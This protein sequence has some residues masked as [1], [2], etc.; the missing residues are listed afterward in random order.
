MSQIPENPSLARPTFA[1]TARGTSRVGTAEARA[2]LRECFAQYRSR[3]IDMTRSSLEM[4]TDLFEWNTQ[5]PE[6]EV[7][8][9]KA[10][11][12]EWLEHFAR[13]IDDLYERRMAGQRRKGRRPDAETGAGNVK[14]L[15][16]FDQSKQEALVHAMEHLHDYTRHEVAALDQRFAALVPERNVGEIDNPFAPAYVLD[17]IGVSSRAIYPDPRIWRP[18]MERVLSDITPS[19]NQIY[20]ALN[21]LLAMH[22]VLPEIN[23]ALR[24]RSALRPA[25]DA[26]LLP[27][28]KDLLAKA[29]M[30]GR[31]GAAPPPA[32]DR[33][34]LPAATVVAALRSL[35]QSKAPAGDRGRGHVA[36]DNDAFPDVDPMLALGGTASAIS[37]LTALQRMDLPTEV[38]R[39]AE[40]S[41]GGKP[42]STLPQNLVPYIREMLGASVQHPAERTTL[43]VVALLFEYASRDPSIPDELRPLVSRLQV[44]ILKGA[45]IDPAFFQ[46]PRNPARHTLDLLAAATIGAT[47]DPSYCAALEALAT[48]VIGE[49]A[50][51]FEV[52][53]TAFD[54]ADRRLAAFIDT[55]SR[56]TAASVMADIRSATASEQVESDRGRVRGLIRDRMAG[57][58]VPAAIRSFVETTWADYLT[59]LRKEH[60]EHSVAASEALRTL[61]DLLWSVVAKERTGQKQRLAKMIPTLVGNLRKGGK[62]VELADERF[63]SFMDELYQLHIAA[64]KQHPVAP[65]ATPLAAPA[66]PTL[67]EAARMKAG[68]SSPGIAV[69]SIHDFVSE[70]V[71]GTWLA[72]Q[73]ERGSVCARLVWTG[74]L[75]MTYVFASRSGLLVFVYSPEDL[76]QALVS[77]KVSLVLEPV[78]LFD[79]AVSSALN[80]LAA[81]PPGGSGERTVAAGG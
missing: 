81:G 80:A 60:G 28:F 70:M 16:D 46:N 42:G 23:A 59:Q 2:L 27:A 64:I 76:A 61:D 45:L 74:A 8:R 33:T 31:A 37:M 52:D 25:D 26:D 10:R 5:V 71:P 36:A 7:E 38:L 24:A 47:D 77:G 49:V 69:A 55:E 73:A 62:A 20:M 72:F 11:R 51:H 9:F 17:A 53:L 75:R 54:E 35:A 30:A 1:D 4:S 15:S 39:E 32:G 68:T 78:P 65:Q 3:L 63:K 40:R 19:V 66:L 44:P 6:A 14:M 57:S 56:K 79:R 67:A 48:D 13:T 43:D 22:E 18:L 58:D 29:G 41:L 21:R 34:A 50:A 12:G